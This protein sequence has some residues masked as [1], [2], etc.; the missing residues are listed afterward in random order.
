M[1]LSFLSG[2]FYSRDVLPVFW[3]KV[4]MFNPFYYLIDG[5]RYGVVGHSGY[6]LF[7]GGVVALVCIIA[8]SV[9]CL[10]MLYTGYELKN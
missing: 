1:P 3:Q 7:V 9:L 2:T 10:R 5:F 6:P 8:V 4:V